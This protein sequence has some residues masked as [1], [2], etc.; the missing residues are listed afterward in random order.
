MG[1]GYNRRVMTLTELRYIVA[2][3]RHRHFGRAAEACFVSQPTLSIAVRKLEDE[4]GVTLFER[5]QSAVTVTPVGERIVQ[6]AQRV[7]EQASVIKEIAQEGKDQLQTP[8][9]LGVIYTIGPYLL[10]HLIPLLHQRAPHMPLVIREDFTD[11][12]GEALRRGELDVIV[13]SL[14]FELPGI[15]TEDLY[16]EPF[17]VAMP[18]DH[19]WTRRKTIKSSDLAAEDVL[20]L[21]AGN[22]FRDQVLEACPNC[23]GGTGP[24]SMQRTLEGS[25]LATIRQMVASGAG[26]TVLPCTS[27]NGGDD[28]KGLLCFRPFEAPVPTRRVALAY[29]RSFPRRDAL[30]VLRE[31]VGACPLSCIRKCPRNA[32]AAG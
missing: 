1:T 3:A 19:P 30:E 32:A 22:C 20:L 25:S 13:L 11:N 18:A 29:R 31:A 14:P 12:L 27:A 15:E 5:G 21:S 9:K 2:V 26:V 16:D 8:L 7:L 28:L 4:L 17:L 23:R 6:Q 24:A 10:P